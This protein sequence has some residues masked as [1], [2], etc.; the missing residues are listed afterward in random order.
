MNWENVYVKK[1]DAHYSRI[2]ASY[3]N[4]LQKL[5]RKFWRDE[6]EQWLRST[7]LFTDD[8]IDDIVEQATCGKL[9]LETSA[10][11]YLRGH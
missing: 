8:E 4:V 7:G 3:R 1:A 11:N 6:F 10:Y 5:G 9:E 2:I